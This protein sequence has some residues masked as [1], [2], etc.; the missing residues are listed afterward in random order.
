M[1]EPQ[2]IRSRAPLRLS[3]GGGGTD[4]APYCDERGGVILSASINRYAYVTIVLRADRR[5]RVASLDY[6]EAIELELD[7]DW[8]SDN[9][10]DLVLG[11]LRRFRERIPCGADIYTHVECPPG[12][13]LGASSTLVV[14]AIG[15]VDR[16]LGI[17]LDRYE[18]ARL[19][20]DIER[21]DLG[22]RGGKQDQ[23]A[24]S[25]GGVNYLELREGRVLVNP[26][27]I[28]DEWLAELEYSLLLVY[29]GTSRHS[30]R[31]IE[32]QI[33]NFEG[34]VTESVGAMDETKALAV[35]M[36]NALLIGDVAGMGRILD[37]AWAVKKRM[38]QYISN[39]HIDSI[40]SA[41]R[42]AG[43]LGGKVSGAGGGGFMFFVTE[44][45]RQ[46]AVAEA[47]KNAGAEI[48]DFGFVKW[49]M[50]T[51]IP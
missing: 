16:W 44:F 20:F 17:G 36:K 48:V 34:R 3:F 37:R 39:E 19:A 49:G 15:A 38:S 4:V 6:D 50:Q 40:Y 1:D 32:D 35:E 12:S 24:A 13:G 51:W 25:F 46:H 41:A 28:P 8:P 5:L 21:K 11:V 26:L 10:F 18:T 43:A 22:I 30:S 2:V 42:Q 29:T 31:I 27:R 23:F 9:R 47:L 45:D 33:A 7:G 14:A